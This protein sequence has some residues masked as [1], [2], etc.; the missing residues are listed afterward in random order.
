MTK[1]IPTLSQG[2][3]ANGMAEE[4]L[5]VIYQYAETCPLAL[6]V[7]VLDMVKFQLMVEQGMVFEEDEDEEE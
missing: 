5:N 3:L 7:G 1:G 4:L 6:V 2:E